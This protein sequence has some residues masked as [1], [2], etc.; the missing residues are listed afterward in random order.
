[1]GADGAIRAVASAAPIAIAAAYKPAGGGA[2]FV[3]TAVGDPECDGSSVT[4]VL[5]GTVGVNSTP[6]MKLI[7]PR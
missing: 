4:Y 2:T 3:M 6:V 1:M 5:E 7:E